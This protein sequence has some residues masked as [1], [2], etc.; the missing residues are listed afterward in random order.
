M[1][2]L[3]LACPAPLPEPPAGEPTEPVLA[4]GEALALRAGGF[5]GATSLYTG[6]TAMLWE[7]HG[8]RALLYLL[9]DTEPVLPSAGRLLT[10]DGGDL[11][12]IPLP[13]EVSWELG[14]AVGRESGSPLPAL[15]RL[16]DG[17][18]L[19]TELA[20]PD[21]T[22]ATE[23]RLFLSDAVLVAARGPSGKAYHGVFGG[24]G[25]PVLSPLPLWPIG[26][27]SD[28]GRVEAWSGRG[29]PGDEG[30]C[31]RYRL[32]GEAPRCRMVDGGPTTDSWPLSG[33][34]TAVASWTGGVKLYRDTQPTPWRL[35]EDCRWTIAATLE[36]PPR[37]LAE[38]HPDRDSPDRLRRLW[39]PD[40]ER[41]WT[42]QLPPAHRGSF[43]TR[44][45]HYPVLAEPIPDV[46][47]T[48]TEHWIDLE[49]GER[50][51][52]QLLSPLS[53]DGV[54]R[55][56]LARDPHT[57][58]VVLLDFESGVYHPLTGA[59]EDCPAELAELGR[60]QGLVL[61]TCLSRPNPS[62]YQFIHHW[63]MVV[64]LEGKRAWRLDQHPEAILG[65][66][67]ILVSDRQETQAEGFTG[68]TS[69]SRLELE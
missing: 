31:V 28:G 44:P 58:G 15:I 56:G 61:L 67:T 21:G 6:S 13:R 39:S 12:E 45:A 24:D 19:T 55:P 63:S 3:L 34:W 9:S 46:S 57:G 20:L 54:S 51:R 65:P 64:D 48:L 16:E 11:G 47:P 27:S 2:L 4:E 66:T 53:Y 30:D 37:V 18:T 33:G 35:E 40:W 8:E 26:M 10:T 36:S 17:A 41:S 38:C 25:E 5:S 62:L 43:L 29:V 23:V 42:Q 68:F 49:S 59:G 32:D 1:I 14:V 60:E 52:S 69:L 22:D 7:A 50:W